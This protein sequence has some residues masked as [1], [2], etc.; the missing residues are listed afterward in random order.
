MSIVIVHVTLKSR[1]FSIFNM[2]II[3]SAAVGT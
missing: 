2:K 1:L 3:K